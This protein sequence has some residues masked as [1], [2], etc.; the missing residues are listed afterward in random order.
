MPFLRP[1]IR[2]VSAFLLLSGAL[3]WGL[4]AEPQYVGQAKCKVCHLTQHK[5]WLATA[6]ARAIEVLKPEERTKPECL[7]CH[8]TG[9]GKPAAAGA[10]LLGVQCEA[11]HGPGSLYK[12]PDVMNKVKFKTDP[13]GMHKKAMELGLTEISERT[14]TACHNSRSPGFKGFDF[15]TAKAKVKH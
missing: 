10:D 12:A 7:A 5:S 2:N 3:G 4:A 14:C 6:H 8:T 15:A 9:Y 13:A 1:A 11:C